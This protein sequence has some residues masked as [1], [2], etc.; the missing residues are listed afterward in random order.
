MTES[1]KRISVYAVLGF[2]VGVLLM[3]LYINSCRKIGTTRNE[4]VTLVNALNDSIRYYKD[5]DSENVATIS[6]LQTE[7]TNDFLILQSKDNSV[8]EL[9]D[10]VKEY[11]DRLKE[12]SSVT[13]TLLE[14][15]NKGLQPTIIVKRDTVVVENP[16]GY[17][18]NYIYP[19]YRQQKRDEWLDYEAEMNKDTSFY[20]IKIFNKFSA[21][22]GRDRRGA[23]ADITTYNPY[24]TVKTLRT[25]Q[26][27]QPKPKLFGF[28]LSTGMTYTGKWTPYLGA[29]FNYNLIRF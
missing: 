14:T 21:V 24:T 25:Y 23:F 6:I 10:I 3:I 17:T 29:G 26:V 8:K 13:T 11:R 7:K 12:G 16:G 15:I 1:A 18:D 4:V 9:Q 27:A 5:K 20:N 19:T 28:G 2:M 22:V